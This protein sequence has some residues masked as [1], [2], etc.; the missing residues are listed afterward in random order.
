[1]KQLK[2]IGVLFL[3]LVLTLSCKPSSN[4]SKG[5]LDTTNKTNVSIPERTDLKVVDLIDIKLL[6]PFEDIK[7]S[8]GSTLKSNGKKYETMS[9]L[10]AVG[11]NAN[12]VF[13][14]DNVILSSSEHPTEIIF[15]FEKGSAVLKFVE[16]KI[17]DEKIGKSL[18]VALNR[19]FGKPSFEQNTDKDNG[20]GVDENGNAIS[21]ANYP[22]QNF[23]VWEKSDNKKSYFVLQHSDGGAKVT[24]LTILDPDEKFAKQFISVRSFDWYNNH[25]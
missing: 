24:E 12:A 22:K 15:H 13:T 19:S 16:V 11:Y 8:D 10:Q 5:V 4:K 7:N 25:Y 6:E 17:S 1:M 20:M 9:G 23:M 2:F 3:V 21:S 14:F 18:L